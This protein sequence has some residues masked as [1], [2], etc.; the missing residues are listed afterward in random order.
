MSRSFLL[1]FAA[2]LLTLAVAVFQRVTGPT[3][4]VS[5]SVR[6]DG[7]EIS[8]RFLRSH[9]SGLD[10]P[11]RVLAPDTSVTGV[12]RWKRFKTA[13]AWTDVPMTREGDVLGGLLPTQLPAGKVEYLVLLRKAETVVAMPKAGPVVLRYKGAVPLWVLLPHIAAMFLAML[14]STRAGLEVFA[15]APR[16][17]LYTLWT[18]TVLA[19]GGLVLGPILQLYAFGALWTGWPLGGD[20][21]DNKTAVALIGW[22]AVLPALRRSRHPGRWVLGAALLLLAVY[23]IPHSLLGSELDYNRP[24][25]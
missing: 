2:T 14:L 5:G 13:D 16:L 1:W 17:R 24:A 18:V 25:G 23:L 15:P 10:A 9:D 21:T 7:G 19:V 22:L 3:Y 4:P 12:L 20:L 11:V 6:T 8:Y